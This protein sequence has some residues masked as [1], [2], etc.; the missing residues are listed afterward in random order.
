MKWITLKMHLLPVIFQEIDFVTESYLKMLKKIKHAADPRDT[1]IVDEADN[2]EIEITIKKFNGLRESISKRINELEDFYE[3][4]I[5]DVRV[6]NFEKARIRLKKLLMYDVD[7][8]TRI[9]SSST[10]EGIFIKDKVKKLTEETRKKL[11]ET[12]IEKQLK[13]QKEKEKEKVLAQMTG[14]QPTLSNYDSK[15]TKRVS[16]VKSINE[17]S[18]NSISN[19]FC[20][21]SCSTEKLFDGG[22]LARC[23]ELVFKIRLSEE[24]WKMLI[25]EK[26]KR[27]MGGVNTNK[28]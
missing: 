23:K 6:S 18:R 17:A 24:E 9:E 14:G 12:N 15:G 5:E 11:L 19:K 27:M 13:E 2:E 26:K 20:S 10:K 8:L 16:I 21:Y 4:N 22:E 3:E 25:K 28:K 1:D 7:I